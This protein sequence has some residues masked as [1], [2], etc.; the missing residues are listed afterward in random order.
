LLRRASRVVAFARPELQLG[1][2]ATARMRADRDEDQMAERMTRAGRA[3]L[4]LTLLTLA[5]CGESDTNLTSADVARRGGVA[6]FS[7]TFTQQI[8]VN[9]QYAYYDLHCLDGSKIT[10][11][12]ARIIAVSGNEATARDYVLRANVFPR[13]NKVLARVSTT[14]ARF[15]GS[16]PAVTLE[17]TVTCTTRPAG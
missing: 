4:G 1:S 7:E 5:A 12:G 9:Q 3:A 6:T 11:G 2:T 17:L 16:P 8:Y 10:R 13:T 15:A 14:R